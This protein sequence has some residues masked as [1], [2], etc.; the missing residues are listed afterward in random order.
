MA[1]QNLI[2]GVGFVNETAT[3]QSLIPGGGFVNETVAAAG[4]STITPGVGSIAVAGYAP[5]PSLAVARLPAA[6]SITFSGYV[7]SVV[8]QAPIYTL[9]SATYVPASITASGV[10][11]RVSVALS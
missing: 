7:P 5:I 9:S 1:T 8:Q 11:A 6:G 3:T 4:G 2:P 10:T